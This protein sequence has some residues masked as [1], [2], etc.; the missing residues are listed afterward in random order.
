MTSMVTDYAK[1]FWLLKTLFTVELR[2][3]NTNQAR[4]ATFHWMSPFCLNPADFD[5]RFRADLL[6]RNPK[7]TLV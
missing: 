3:A 6:W 1:L 5:G 2:R 7:R 4:F